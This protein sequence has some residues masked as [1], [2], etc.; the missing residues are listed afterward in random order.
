MLPTS[1]TPEKPTETISDAVIFSRIIAKNFLSIPKIAE[2][3]SI[4]RRNIQ[5]MVKMKGSKAIRKADA[6]FMSS[7][8]AEEK[9]KAEQEAGTAKKVT[10]VKKEEEGTGLFGKF[11][12][13]MFDKF[14]STKIGGK[15]VSIGEKLLKGFKAIFSPKNFMKLLG[16]LALPL[17]I[18]SALFEG[19]VSAFD[20]WKET[21]SIWE[22]FKAGIGG[23]V[24]F[25]TF[26]L[27]DKKMVS[28]F[29]DWQIG[30]IEKILKS[31]AD[32]FGFG[33]LFTEKFDKVKKKLRVIARATP[34]DRLLLV[35]GIKQKGGLIG[36][37]GS[38]IADADALKKADV[39][40][41]MGI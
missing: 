38:S 17:L 29:Y 18:F 39:G 12:K 3:M 8:K 33:D 36:M 26:G 1:P 9:L 32:F 13:K 35:C 27:I 19:F 14:K 28:N 22:A 5:N 10:P 11:G 41:A 24:E 16:R 20:M 15:V 30:A 25:L 40:F 7:S 4:I 34:E 2:D 37:A 6:E 31:V 21:G 23:I